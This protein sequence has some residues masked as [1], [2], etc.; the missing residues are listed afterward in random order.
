ML[1]YLPLIALVGMHGTLSPGEEHGVLEGRLRQ[2][3]LSSIADA[4]AA[5][6][7]E[8]MRTVIAT[9]GLGFP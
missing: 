8:I 7:G 2:R 4:F 6:P 3:W 5:G 1:K 9:R